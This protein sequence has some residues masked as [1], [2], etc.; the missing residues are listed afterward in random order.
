MII[1]IIPVVVVVDV[2]PFN[3]QILD[4]PLIHLQA[5]FKHMVELV[6]TDTKVRKRQLVAKVQYMKIVAT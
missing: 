1:D 3:V 5:H 4:H 2:L 6:D